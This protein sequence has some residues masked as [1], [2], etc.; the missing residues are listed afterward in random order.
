MLEEGEAEAPNKK[1]TQVI[2]KTFSRSSR[3]RD[4]VDADELAD[5]S[6]ARRRRRSHLHRA[7]VAATMA[8][9]SP[10][11]TTSAA[12]EDDV[13]GFHHASAASIM[14]MRPRVSIIPSASPTSRFTFQ[15]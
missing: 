14:P 7:H 6:R 4:H 11:S 9:T 10:A 8:V 13:G 5:A 1:T 2:G 3:P 12:D 15:P